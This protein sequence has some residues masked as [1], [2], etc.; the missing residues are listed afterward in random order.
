M[1]KLRIDFS[2]SNGKLRPLIEKAASG[3]TRPTLVVIAYYHACGGGRKARF[4]KAE[5]K[6]ER[7]EG[8]RVEQINERCVTM[9]ERE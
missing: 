4:D 1:I 7:E 5:K 2:I 6:G 8:R 3:A 9:W